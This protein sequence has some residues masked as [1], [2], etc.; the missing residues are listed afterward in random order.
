LL[1]KLFRQRESPVFVRS[2][3]EGEFAAEAVQAR[4]DDHHARPTFI[5]RG[6]P[7]QNGSIESF[8]DRLRDE[9]LNREWFPSLAEA[10]VVIE[11]W[12]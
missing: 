6:Q 11:K 5:L 2:D 1:R 9:C 7:W 8:H 12:R 4:L 3:N 10:R